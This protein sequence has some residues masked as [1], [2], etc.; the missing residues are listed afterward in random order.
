[1][2]PGDNFVPPDLSIDEDFFFC[3]IQPEVITQ[4]SCASGAAGEGGSCHS[5]ASALRL[6]P[7]AERESV[8]CEGDVPV[9]PVPASYEANLDAVRVTVRSDPLSSP[10]YRRPIGL[11]SHP[12][13]IFPSDSPEAMLII[14]WIG[15]GM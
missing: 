7:M 2:D 15:S 10:F 3:R 6:D 5:A 4:H 8:R 11:D 1:M 13:E 9:G 12:R 14:E